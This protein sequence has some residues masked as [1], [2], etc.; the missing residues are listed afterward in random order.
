M[1]M[2]SFGQLRRAGRISSRVEQFGRLHLDYDGI[3]T[4][5]LSGGLAR[6]RGGRINV[7][8]PLDVN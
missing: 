3:G 2:P 7:D 8:Q 4:G 5:K 1:K 6:C